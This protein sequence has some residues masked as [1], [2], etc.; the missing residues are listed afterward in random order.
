[1]FPDR[2]GS[3]LIQPQLG[4]KKNQQ[5]ESKVARR[6]VDRITDR[7]QMV[8]EEKYEPNTLFPNIPHG[9]KFLLVIVNETILFFKLYY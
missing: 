4:S 5:L 6:D 1:M 3:Q 9:T 2:N 8:N 7:V